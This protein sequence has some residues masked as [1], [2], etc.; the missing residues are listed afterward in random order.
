MSDE[1]EHKVFGEGAGRVSGHVGSLAEAR[2]VNA[3]GPG[4]AGPESEPG[5]QHEHG[6]WSSVALQGG[7]NRP[8]AP[9]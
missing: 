5:Q 9:V 7:P 6:A 3:S 8:G 2:P 1:E 4:K